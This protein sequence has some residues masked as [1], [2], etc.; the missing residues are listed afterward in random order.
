MNVHF[1]ISIAYLSFGMRIF[2]PMGSPGMRMLCRLLAG[3]GL[4]IGHSLT[5]YAAINKLY[6]I[7][8]LVIP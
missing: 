3:L 6:V 8:I 1:R 2:E 4:C 7:I 5:L